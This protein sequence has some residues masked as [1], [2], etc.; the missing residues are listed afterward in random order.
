MYLMKSQYQIRIFHGYLHC[1][2]VKKCRETIRVVNYNTK[3]F[4]EVLKDSKW[5]NILIY[6]LKESTETN[7]SSGN[8]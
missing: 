4:F 1:F 8:H 3:I 5:Q 6:C 2:Y 7:V